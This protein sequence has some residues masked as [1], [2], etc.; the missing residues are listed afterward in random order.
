MSRRWRTLAGALI[1]LGLS[2]PLY[3]G[4]PPAGFTETALVPG[5]STPTD[6]AFS[7]IDGAMWILE[8]DGTVW[9]WRSPGPL[10][11]VIDIPTDNFF[12]R[13]LLGI[14]F[15]PAFA[16]NHYVYL[17]YTTSFTPKR[18]RV[19]RYVESNDTLTADT[20]VIDDLFVSAGNHNG[21]VVKF[22]PD[23]KLY[24]GV[25]ENAVSSN[26]QDLSNP[27]GKV[28]RVN[29]D[30]TTPTDNPFVGQAGA[31]D[32]IWAYGLRNP[33]RLDFDPLNGDLYIG[34]VGQ[35]AI[36]E[37][38]LGLKGFN[39]RWPQCE[40]TCGTGTG[41]ENPIHQYPHQGGGGAITGGPVY[42]GSNFP[43]SY[44]GRYFYGDYVIGFVRVLTLDAS[45]NVLA[46][47]P[48]VTNAD[49]PVDIEIGPDG[50]L[51][52]AGYGSGTIFQVCNNNPPP[53]AG[54]SGTPLS[55]MAPL[56][57]AFTDLS[58]G[59]VA[60]WAWDFGDG[61]TSTNQNPSHTYASAG[62]YDVALTV[63]GP[64]GSDT[65]TKTGYVNVGSF[66]SDDLITGLGPSAAAAP[67][68]Q[69]WDNTGVANTA[70]DF[71]AYGTG[72][73]GVNVGRG[74]LDGSASDE[75]LSGPGPSGVFGPQVR[76]FFTPTATPVAKVNFYAYGT[77]RYGVRA[78]GV[79]FD[80]DGIGEI[81]TTPGP[82]AVF[83]PH[84]RGF[85]WDGGTLASV[86]KI[87]FFA[88]STLKF[89]AR[90]NGGEIDGDTYHELLV[91]A[92]PG[93]VFGASVRGFNYD[94]AALSAI[95]KV[96]F[97]AYAGT[98]FGAEIGL[99]ELDGDAF[100]EIVTGPGAAVANPSTVRGF[101]YDGA[102]LAQL[103]G[104]DF[105]AYTPSQYGVLVGAGDVDSDGVG[106]ILTMPADPASA[107]RGRGWDY[108]GSTVTAL[109]SLD[110]VADPSARYGG[111]I[112][113]GDFGF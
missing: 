1:A 59:N 108:D 74:N 64:G 2:F 30:G 93:A 53:T 37:V 42:R 15:D 33:W 8:Q 109:S 51:Y 63:T 91:G 17:Y 103:T 4:T 69:A 27:K 21:G 99:G 105:V 113:S 38:D 7:P 90:G 94:A 6:I 79:D 112:D 36:E 45:H 89:G 29:T 23:D 50:C 95:A 83:G 32:R 18:N 96:N 26:A 54:F 34:D 72:G 76:A 56:Q 87:N 82:G 44:Q 39:Y 3:A 73:Y 92:G 66:V 81:F 9:V 47:D 100:D 46:D 80:G 70:I 84:G 40:G 12:E 10:K 49:S 71:N 58:T 104:V 98:T 106:E 77:L 67:R 68:V 5:L 13:G 57:V 60:S 62:S 41:F 22:G 19:E 75:I 48:F 11:F 28:L 85:N 55:G 102:T 35:N 31:D 107:P 86:S 52:Y 43:P 16:T 61:A 101:D 110:F 25:G 88:F 78:E 65:E 24:I 14:A 97:F 111:N 20:L